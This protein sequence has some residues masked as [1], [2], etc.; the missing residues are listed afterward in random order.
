MLLIELCESNDMVTFVDEIEALGVDV[1][2][3]SC[4]DRCSQCLLFPYVYADGA[5]IERETSADV[6]EV[7]RALKKVEEAELSNWLTPSPEETPL[8]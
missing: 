1:V 5:V 6:M 4:L 3:Y 2:T 8:D 7:I